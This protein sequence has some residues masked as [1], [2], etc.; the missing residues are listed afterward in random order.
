MVLDILQRRF[1]VVMF[2][3][4]MCLIAI[5]LGVKLS[6]SYIGTADY[7]I[8]PFVSFL[9]GVTWYLTFLTVVLGVNNKYWIERLAN[10]KRHT[11]W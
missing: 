3:W 11:N 2:I 9:M 4:V 7:P 6:A 1:G 8:A 5:T 10:S